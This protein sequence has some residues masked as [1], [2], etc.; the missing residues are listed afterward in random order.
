M[1]LTYLTPHARAASLWTVGFLT[2]VAW[3]AVAQEPVHLDV[4][5][6]I[7]EEGFQRS[8]VMDILGYM[9]DVLGPRLTGSVG[10]RRAQRW[11]QAKMDSMGL[12]STVIEPFGEHGVSWDN[13]YTSLHML[14]PDYQPLIGYPYAFTPGTD[15]VLITNAVIV[16]IATREDFD[17]YRGRLRGAIVLMSAPRPTAPRFTADAQRFSD[18]DLDAM[19]S[20][21]IA[22]RY[23]IG[24]QDYA[25]D[26]VLNSFVGQ[27]AGP[28]PAATGP[29]TDDILRFFEAEGVGLVLTAA[30]GSDGTVFVTGR[31]GSR[32]DRS[33]EGVFRSPPMVALAAE[34]YNRIY[35][36]T[37][38]GIPVILEVEIRNAIEDS[39][40]LAYNVLGELPG[41]DLADQLVMVGG[42]FDSWHAGT[43][44]TDDGAGCAVALEAVRILTAI[45]ARPRRTIRLGLWSWEEGGKGGSRAY[46]RDHFGHPDTATTPAYDRL[47]AYFNMDNGTGQFRGVYL[48]G[49]ER[50]RP[51]FSAWMAPLRDLGMTTLTIND[52]Y[53]V[54]IVGF[55][56]AGLPAFQFIQ[57]PM[58][59]D[60]RT[61][62]SNMDVY[63]KLIPEDLRKNAVILATFLYHAAMR[64]ERLPRETL[65]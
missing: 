38:R 27:Q 25:W 58:D 21:T 14:E 19:A 33:Y 31:P 49:N 41:T 55:D 6:Q 30:A 32:L 44:A 37:Q 39:D 28:S 56:M 20:A 57:D 8:Q 5:A 52:T 1:T 43:G 36:I 15:G 7:R 17:R 45:G 26:S 22:S 18:D 65:H 64:D 46:V 47:S 3:K 24:Q 16:R 63:D 13:Q 50:V 23:G 48:Q 12:V 60:T 54:D 11:A 4:V 34:H 62:H 51:I 9:T 61:H 2:A 40:P 29:S 59:Y 53:G 35:R 10:M 42:H